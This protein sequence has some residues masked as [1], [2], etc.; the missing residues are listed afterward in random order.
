[1][2]KLDSI[3]SEGLSAAYIAF[4]NKEWVGGEDYSNPYP[5]DTKEHKQWRNGWDTAWKDI[6][7]YYEL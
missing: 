2:P 6:E 5:K 4:D 3:W 1:M 7:A